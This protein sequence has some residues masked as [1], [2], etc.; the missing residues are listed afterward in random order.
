MEVQSPQ[1]VQINFNNKIITL[2][3]VTIVKNPKIITIDASAYSNFLK[4]SPVKLGNGIP[5]TTTTAISPLKLSMP[6]LVPLKPSSESPQLVTSRV[7]CSFP[8][9]TLVK[10]LPKFT[11]AQVIKTIQTKNS[12]TTNP[13]ITPVKL[14]QIPVKTQPTVI[15]SPPKKIVSNSPSPVKVEAP[16]YP[17][18]STSTV[19]T[20]ETSI[21]VPTKVIISPPL[22]NKISP[23]SLTSPE[24]KRRCSKLDFR[25][26]FCN[27]VYDDSSLLVEHLKQQH[28]QS[29]KIPSQDEHEQQDTEEKSKPT[30]E[31][32]VLPN[33]PQSKFEEHVPTL[34]VKKEPLE[35]VQSNNDHVND[36]IDDDD[37]FDDTNFEYFSSILEPICELNCENDSNEE[38]QDENEAMRLYRE[39]MEMNYLQNGIKKRGRR[40]RHNSKPLV[41]NT[42]AMN[43]ILAGL[44]DTTVL[45]VP[46]GPGRGRRKE[47]DEKELEID[48]SN[49]VCLF[50]CNRC[51]E[52]FKYAGDLAK[53]V[54]SHT[55]SSPY[56]CS[57]C[58]RKFTHIGSLNT[59]LRIHSGERPYKCNQCDKSFT[60]SNSLMV[61]VKSHLSNKPFQCEQCNKGFLNASSLALHQKT[62]TGPTTVTCPIDECG[63]EF[64]DNNLLEEHMMTHR[65]SLLYQCSL[66]SEKFEQSCLLVQHVKSHIGDKPFQCNQCG[67]C[68]TQPGSLNTHLRIHTGEKPFECVMCGK[69]FTQASSLSVHMKVHGEKEFKCVI[70]N[71]KKSYSQEAYLKKHMMKHIEASLNF[72]NDHVKQV[73]AE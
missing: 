62:H 12:I 15:I 71:C 18:T 10:Q 13:P 23:C 46:K 47:I 67:K 2:H 42:I 56:Q 31:E 32:R 70:E 45:K 19:P 60:Q 35:E 33:L 9:S 25:C 17:Q 27:E 65:L 66:C 59:H 39:A 14:Q 36:E 21:A 7:A 38:V 8:N 55:I 68:F 29:V 69:R 6:T 44:L 43:G 51:D 30:E 26:L 20:I 40:K 49:G 16:I 37:E 28:P 73:A 61:H 22:K 48:R 24:R 72:E 53:H 1:S 54:R 64:R 63:K 34:S 58:Q 5:V 4:G 41:E 50:S 3:N 52:T 57:I 11:T